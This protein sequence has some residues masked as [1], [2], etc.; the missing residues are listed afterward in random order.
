MQ[1]FHPS[2]PLFGPRDVYWILEPNLAIIFWIIVK[3][4][5]TFFSIFMIQ[6]EE[7]EIEILSTGCFDVFD[8][9][10][11][12]RLFADLNDDAVF[13]NLERTVRVF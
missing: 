7:D 12:V 9:A 3:G 4:E 2:L 6:E 10:D 1:L 11:T 13:S 8:R 5:I